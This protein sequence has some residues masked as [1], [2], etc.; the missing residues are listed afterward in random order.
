MA[1]SSKAPRFLLALFLLCHCNFGLSKRRNAL[2]I[3]GNYC[4]AVDIGVH[5]QA[6]FLTSSTMCDQRKLH[7]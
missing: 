7:Y 3:I 1:P 6:G 2:L 4:A 5:D